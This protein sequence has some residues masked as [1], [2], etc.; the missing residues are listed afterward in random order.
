M[1][2]ITAICLIVF[3]LL[4][5]ERQPYVE[6]KADLKKKAD[7]CTGMQPSF[8]L[9]SNFGGERYEFQKCLPA[10]YNKSLIISERHGDTVLV[11]FPVSAGASTTALYQVTLDID[12]YP[13]Y[14]FVTIDDATYLVGPSDK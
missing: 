10:D 3:A 2:K 14:S 13:K 4:A 1:K 12:S 9:E 7:D 5:C 8:R 6:L 11:R